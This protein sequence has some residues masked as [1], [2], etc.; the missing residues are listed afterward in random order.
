[1]QTLEEYTAAVNALTVEDI[2]KV[3]EKYLKHDEYVRVSL[4]PA[5]MKPAK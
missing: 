1:M 4:K 3:A 2:K 5:A